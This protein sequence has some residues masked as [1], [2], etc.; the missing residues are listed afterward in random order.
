MD[1]NIADS[2]AITLEAR[3]IPNTLERRRKKVALT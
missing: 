1:N 3:T 2:K